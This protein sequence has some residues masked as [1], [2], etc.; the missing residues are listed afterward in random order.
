MQKRRLFI[1]DIEPL[2]NRYTKQ[3]FT[4]VPELCRRILGDQYEV[5]VISGN[6]L[7]Y[8]KPRAGAFFDFAAT[9]EYKAS[10]A[11][12][13]SQLFSDGEVEPND[14][15]FFTDAWN[16]TVHTVRYI[17]ELNRIPV[18][19]AG[20][21]HAGWYDPTDILGFT[22][23]RHAWV[24]HM[25][26]SMYSAYDVN[27]F[28]TQ[29]HLDKFMAR[30]LQMRSTRVEEQSKAVV[31]GYPLEYI[32]DLVND[33]KK[34]DIVVFPHRLNPDKAPYIFDAIREKLRESHPHIAFFKTQEADLSKEG[35]YNFL[36]KCKVVFSANRHENLGIG[37]FEAMMA[38]CLPIVPRK[39]SYA[40]MYQDPFLYD[41]ADDFYENPPVDMLAAKVV[42]FVE[43]YESYIPELDRQVP[44]I[45][46]KF[47]TGT[48]MMKELG[49]L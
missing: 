41:V 47:F 15:F 5:R 35:Y 4:W 44:Y 9:C 6:A 27:F 31:V 22:I 3:W 42:D 28:G 8:L 26:K 37:T 34:L 2:D 33:G 24:A 39:L 11:V 38:G 13:I 40:E 7:G 18:K 20:I 32:V 12:K 25:E 14:V 21:W 29:Q 17:S 30:H 16:Q 49:K 45:M 1:V 48:E 46:E 10:Q 19:C 36:M 43:N 23:K